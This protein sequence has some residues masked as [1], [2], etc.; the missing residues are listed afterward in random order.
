MIAGGGGY[1]K[2][3]V[4]RCWANE[5]GVLVDEHVDDDIPPHNFYYQYYS[6]ANYKLR[7]ESAEVQA[8]KN[9]QAYLDSVKNTLLARLK[10]LEHAPSVQLHYPPPDSM[11]PETD[12]ADL[13][14]DDIVSQLH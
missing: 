11:L 2:S 12:D 4:A 14:R 13:L 10:A 9:E 5:T 1:T 8:N 3:N 7:V 6:D